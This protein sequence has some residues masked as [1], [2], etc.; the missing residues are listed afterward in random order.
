MTKKL[1]IAQSRATHF[2]QGGRG[3]RQWVDAIISRQPDVLIYTDVGMDPMTLKLASL[4]LAPVS[5]RHM[6]ASRN[7][8]PADDRLLSVRPGH[9]AARRAGQTTPSNS[10]P[11]P[12]LGCFYQARQI[13]SVPADASA[14]G[15]EHGVPLLVSPGMP[16]KYAL[17][18]D[19]IFAEIA[20]RLERCRIVFFRL[21]PGKCPISCVSG[22]STSFTQ[23]GLILDRF[24]SFI[25]WQTPAGILWIDEAGDFVS[26][27]DRLFRFQYGDGS[28]GMR[29]A[30]RD[31]GRRFLRGRF[32]S[33]S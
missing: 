7:E 18:H 32:S 22:S 16:F 17:Q 24:V 5:S 2:E 15:I 33:E 8:R 6:G 12:H 3:L 19:W 13:D 21:W 10:L 26:R 23:R 27:Y 4:R 14:W 1:G 9:G 25:P 28:G 31:T 11:L 20:R 29:T 30:H